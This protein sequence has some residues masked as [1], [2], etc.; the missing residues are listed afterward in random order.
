MVFCASQ[1]AQHKRHGLG[2]SRCCSKTCRR[3]C[4]MLLRHGFFFAFVDVAMNCVSQQRVG[5]ECSA[6]RELEG[7]R[8]S[9]LMFFIL[10]IVHEKF[11]NDLQLYI[12]K[13]SMFMLLKHAVEPH[14][15]IPNHDT[16]TCCR[17]TC[18]PVELSKQVFFE[19]FTTCE[20]VYIYKKTIPV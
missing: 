9:T 18:L 10:L 3:F 11:L 19:R 20:R 12:E 16:V 7:R 13:K 14:S 5:F 6:T 8:Y 1:C 15:F 17:L 4:W 2:G